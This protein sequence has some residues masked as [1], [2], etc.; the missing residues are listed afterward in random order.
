M[1][2]RPG[3]EPGSGAREASRKRMETVRIISLKECQIL[4]NRIGGSMSEGEV[5]EFLP[6]K[7]NAPPQMRPIP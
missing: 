2:L 5:V 6:P 4:H 3:F 1:V 7:Q